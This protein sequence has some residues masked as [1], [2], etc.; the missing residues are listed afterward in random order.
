[1]FA[2]MRDDHHI[3]AGAREPQ[4][5]PDNMARSTHVGTH[6]RQ[7]PALHRHRSRRS[8]ERIQTSSP[9]MHHTLPIRT[10]SRLPRSADYEHVVS[11]PTVPPQSKT[12]RPQPRIAPTERLPPNHFDRSSKPRD[13]PRERADHY[14]HSAPRSSANVRDGSSKSSGMRDS[15]PRDTRRED[16]RDRVVVER[17]R[18]RHVHFADGVR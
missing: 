3:F 1:M 9:A 14:R 12:S 10:S 16:R 4:Y 8:A 6:E 15:R 5:R 17:P 18:V 13:V 11:R 2:R 7:R